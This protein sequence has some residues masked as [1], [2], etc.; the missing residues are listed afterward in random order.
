MKGIVT[1]MACINLSLAGAAAAGPGRDNPLLL[2]W[3][4]PEGTPPF[5]RIELVDIEPAMVAAMA[6]HDR[7]IA[8]IGPMP[9]VSNGLFQMT[10]FS[11]PGATIQV[12]A[13]TNLVHW[14]TIAILTNLTGSY[15]FTDPVSGF[16]RR[17]YQAVGGP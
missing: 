16:S 14:D 4:T 11:A 10:L 3:D 15:P 9:S 17:F 1:A 7:E 2:A 6:E 12:R 13:S 8:A 5:A